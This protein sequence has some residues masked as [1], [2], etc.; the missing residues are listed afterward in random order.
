MEMSIDTTNCSFQHFSESSMPRLGSLES[1][2]VLNEAIS[3]RAVP[4][5][6]QGR[7][8]VLRHFINNRGLT[9]KKKSTELWSSSRTRASR[10]ET[11]S[12]RR[13]GEIAH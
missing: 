12:E 3:H 13:K 7:V 5:K 9:K 2:A 4:S 10:S 11:E 8:K 6:A 1:L